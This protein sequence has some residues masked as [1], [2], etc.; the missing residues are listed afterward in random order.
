MKNKIIL[1]LGLL[2]GMGL[3]ACSSKPTANT[4]PET[5]RVPAAASH[6]EKLPSTFFKHGVGTEVVQ[7]N[8]CWIVKIDPS[9]PDLQRYFMAGTPADM[10]LS[11]ADIG[12]YTILG[13]IHYNGFGGDGYPKYRDAAHR[14][15]SYDEALQILQTNEDCTEW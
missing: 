7:T 14:A 5:P 3:G 9:E 4:P 12:K 10:K 1:S 8:Y 6:D 15:V 13:E 2:V 11:E